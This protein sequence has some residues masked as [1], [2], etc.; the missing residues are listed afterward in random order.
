M[1]LTQEEEFRLRVFENG[2]VRKIIEVMRDE[3]TEKWRRLHNEGLSAVYVPP[4]LTQVIELRRLNWARHVACM[5]RRRAHTRFWWIKPEG[6][7][8]PRRSRRK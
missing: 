4:N 6:R 7:R 3:V 8:P 5:G 2:V 1:V